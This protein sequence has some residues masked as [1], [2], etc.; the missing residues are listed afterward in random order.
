MSHIP[1]SSV[2]NPIQEVTVVEVSTQTYHPE[3]L[4]CDDIQRMLQLLEKSSQLSPQLAKLLKDHFSSRK[5]TEENELLKLCSSNP[6]ADTEKDS[7]ASVPKERSTSCVTELLSSTVSP[8]P[9]IHDMNSAVG[10]SPL[11]LT[12]GHSYPMD[13]IEPSFRGSS[14]L[15]SK[16][17][18]NSAKQAKLAKPDDTSIELNR[19]HEVGVGSK[20]SEGSDG[21]SSVNVMDASSPSAAIARSAGID[22]GLNGDGM[23]MRRDVQDTSEGSNIKY[24]FLKMLEID[25][26]I[27]KLMEVKFEL[28]KKLQLSL[29]IDS[30]CTNRNTSHSPKSREI[31]YA[32]PSTAAAATQTQCNRVVLGS[33][34]NTQQMHMGIVTLNNNETTGNSFTSVRPTSTSTPM[35]MLPIDYVLGPSTE[36]QNT[37]LSLPRHKINECLK[38][39]D[40]SVVEAVLNS[41]NLP[42]CQSIGEDSPM[43]HSL[44]HSNHNK[45]SGDINGIS[46]FKSKSDQLDGNSANKSRRYLA[47]RFSASHKESHQP[48]RNSSSPKVTSQKRQV[49]KPK[50][51][52]SKDHHSGDKE[53][54]LHVEQH[55]GVTMRNKSS[56]PD[57]NQ[58]RSWLESN[59]DATVKKPIQ[60]DSLNQ[61]AVKELRSRSRSTRQKVGNMKCEEESSHSDSIS[62]VEDG[63]ETQFL[64][65]TEVLTENSKQSGNDSSSSSNR[66]K[67]LFQRKSDIGKSNEQVFLQASNS[68]SRGRRDTRTRSRWDVGP[69]CE[70]VAETVRSRKGT[71][72]SKGRNSTSFDESEASDDCISRVTQKRKP[73]VKKIDDQYGS[74]SQEE[75]TKSATESRVRRSS[76]IASDSQ[77][78]QPAVISENSTEMGRKKMTLKLEQTDTFDEGALPARR[79]KRTLVSNSGLPQS[80]NYSKV[81]SSPEVLK[82]GL[83]SEHCPS[84]RSR[85]HVDGTQKRKPDEI[86]GPASKLQHLNP[87]P[88]LLQWNIQDCF[89]MVKQLAVEEIHDSAPSEELAITNS[90]RSKRIRRSSCSSD[91]L[92]V[93]EFV[94]RSK[95]M[96]CGVKCKSNKSDDCYRVNSAESEDEQLHQTVG[97]SNQQ[98][99]PGDIPNA[100][101]CQ[102]QPSEFHIEPYGNITSSPVQLRPDL[103]MQS[104]SAGQLQGQCILPE[105]AVQDENSISTLVSDTMSV[106]SDG[107]H[108][109]AKRSRSDERNEADLLT[110][111][112]HG[113]DDCDRDSACSYDTG[114]EGKEGTNSTASKHKSS[115][116]HK[117]DRKSDSIE[118]LVFES[119]EGPILHIKVS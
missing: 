96:G 114:Q 23:N 112:A 62:M 3:E 64:V 50:P 59:S 87:K 37:H 41:F 22:S 100:P 53:T 88:D 116:K 40:T 109:I 20:E 48:E 14:L 65:S 18:K 8:S 38:T 117:K 66:P 68:V 75:S 42:D 43:T 63:N 15:S 70:E 61:Y 111:S 34:S 98:D 80:G 108:A 79:L 90:S 107:E 60:S 7:A 115:K 101:G 106:M 105:I 32:S 24:V 13:G 30:S 29:E 95:S 99:P 84:S 26:E 5:I 57:G 36:L 83:S 17:R 58:E 4:D 91:E 10:T 74:S 110:H 54:Q 93:T 104:N 28:Y 56:M 49:L 97:S 103:L 25:K 27:Q 119:H 31:Q 51:D 78:M 89:V 82:S 45:T 72:S 9:L 6:P 39:F 46:P 21:V 11:L 35:V 77:D 33:N 47:P 19:V 52:V 85:R 113:K 2:Y 73:V 118:R 16:G 44:E 81:Q 102:A 12:S 69:E 67:R 55:I 71:R 1:L 86:G 94:K 92:S 76:R